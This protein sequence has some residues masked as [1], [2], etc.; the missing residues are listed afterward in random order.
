K[1]GSRDGHKVPQDL[2]ASAARLL[3]VKLDAEDV[4][5]FD[6][7]G[8][9]RSMLTGCRGLAGQRRRIRVSEVD[10]AA[11]IHSLKQPRPVRQVQGVPTDV[12]HLDAGSLPKPRAL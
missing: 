10:L 6:G 3:R 7:G 9:D 8:E 2:D 11:F 1:S 5:H 4:I 12:R